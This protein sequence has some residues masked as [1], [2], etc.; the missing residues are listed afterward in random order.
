MILPI[1]TP[2]PIFFCFC[3][4][5]FFFAQLTPII[6]GSGTYPGPAQQNGSDGVTFA[7]ARLASPQT[8]SSRPEITLQGKALTQAT[9]IA[10]ASPPATFPSAV[11]TTSNPGQDQTSSA[12]PLSD[13]PA[14][15][16]R[17]TT[18]GPSQCILGTYLGISV[19][20]TSARMG[21]GDTEGSLLPFGLRA[22]LSA[23]Y[24]IRRTQNSQTDRQTAM[25]S[26]LTDTVRTPVLY[27]LHRPFPL[28]WLLGAVLSDL[29]QSLD[30]RSG[31]FYQWSISPYQNSPFV[32]AI[33]IPRPGQKK[34]KKGARKEQMLWAGIDSFPPLPRVSALLRFSTPVLFRT[35]VPLL[36]IFTV[37]LR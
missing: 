7:T 27:F 35:V 28:C 8:L 4:V 9:I 29:N 33:E 23:N 2:S 19:G 30:P 31:L 17:Q 25:H 11:P 34:K 13:H 21:L 24:R 14:P 3:F 22:G 26:C 10:G 20:W 36:R 1:S 12:L 37:R 32:L 15:S 16:Y 5:F 6:N 18:P